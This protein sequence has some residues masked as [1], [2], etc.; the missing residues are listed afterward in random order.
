MTVCRMFKVQRKNVWVHRLQ[1]PNLPFSL[2]SYRASDTPRIRPISEGIVYLRFPKNVLLKVKRFPCSLYIA[3]RLYN[4]NEAL[5]TQHRHRGVQLLISNELF[6]M[7]REYSHSTTQSDRI[8]R[9]YAQSIEPPHQ[10]LTLSLRVIPRPA[11]RSN[12]SPRA[13]AAR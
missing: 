2:I 10:T 9:L 13:P 4:S 6:S 5:N 1:R 11:H 7:A 12:I 3:I 8:K